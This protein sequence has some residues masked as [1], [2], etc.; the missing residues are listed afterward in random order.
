V[1]LSKET[2]LLGYWIS[3]LGGSSF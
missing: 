1:A 2:L 3:A